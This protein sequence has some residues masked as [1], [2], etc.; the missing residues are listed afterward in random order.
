MVEGNLTLPAVRS[1]R[2]V[3][4]KAGMEYYVGTTVGLFST[5]TINGS[6]TVWSRE[7]GGN[8]MMNTAVVN[9]LAYRWQDNTLLV[10]THG[11]GMFVANIGNAISIATP[12]NDPIRDDK[13]FVVK[14]YPTVATSVINY[15][16][17]NMLGIK[18]VQVQ[19]YNLGGQVMVNK[20]AAYGS[21]NV[22]VSRLPAGTYILTITSS[23]RKYQ[24]I[25]RFVK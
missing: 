13:N 20:T 7:N 21:G 18:N 9:S 15:Q 22:D 11:N 10:G 19:V 17:G 2:I 23:D 8:G 6:S 3:A 24:F 12:V 14:A 25:Q 5:N 16:A 4:T 1:C